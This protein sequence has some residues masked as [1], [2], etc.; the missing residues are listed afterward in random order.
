MAFQ[1]GDEHGVL[2]NGL[3]KIGG[4]TA[5]GRHIGSFYRAPPFGKACADIGEY[6]RDAR[7][8]DDPVVA[9]FTRDPGNRIAIYRCGDE[10]SEA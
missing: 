6:I 4:Y 1:P 10:Q 3:L 7:N 2:S 8:D 5:D 9:E